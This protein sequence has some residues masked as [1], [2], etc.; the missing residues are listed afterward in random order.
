MIR[1][2]AFREPVIRKSD[3]ELVDFSQW[4]MVQDEKVIGIRRAVISANFKGMQFYA[5]GTMSALFHGQTC[6]N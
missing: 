4:K 5:V 1:L 2:H 6:D 3:L